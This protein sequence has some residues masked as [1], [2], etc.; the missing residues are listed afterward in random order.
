MTSRENAPKRFL[1][2]MFFAMLF[3][4]TGKLVGCEMAEPDPGPE[5]DTNPHDAGDDCGCED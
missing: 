3:L 1:L 5:F 2:W 4:A